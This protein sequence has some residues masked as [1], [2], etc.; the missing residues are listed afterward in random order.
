MA[1]PRP[2]GGA[3]HRGHAGHDRGDLCLARSTVGHVDAVISCFGWIPLICG[4]SIRASRMFRSHARYNRNNTQ[5]QFLETFGDDLSAF[6]WPSH[7]LSLFTIKIS[8]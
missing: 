4:L 8:G 3:K 1:F 2:A 5:S 6:I 7:S